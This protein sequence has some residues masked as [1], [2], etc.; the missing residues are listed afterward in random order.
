MTEQIYDR[1]KAIV[2][3]DRVS[4]DHETLQQY[5][6]DQSFVRPCPP[7]YV[8][9]AESVQEI[10]DVVK[11]ANESKTPVVPVSSRMNLRGA[12]IPKEGGI[13]LD[14]SRMNKIGEISE[15]ERWAVVEPGVTYGQLSE[16]LQKHGFRVMIPLG[17][18]RSRSVVSSIIERDPALAAA[19][20][21]YGN[22]I[23][24]EIAMVLPSGEIFRTG[25]WRM[26]LRGEWSSPGGGGIGSAQTCYEWLWHKAQGTLGIITG[27]VV[28][29]EHF[30]K[31]SKVFVFPFDRLE[32]AIEPIRKIQRKELGL[33]CFLLNNF[34]LAAIRTQDWDVPEGFPCERVPST[35]FNSL[36]GRLP[37]WTMIIHLAGLPYFPEEK[38]A[39]EEAD[40][41]DVCSEMGLSPAQT[42]VGEEGLE[43]T[44]LDLTL[45][46]WMSLKKARFKGSFHPVSFYTTLGRVP[47]FEEA[48]SALAQKYGYS[49]NDI[50][51]YL[52]PVERG[53]NCYYEIDFHCDL[54]DS[55]EVRR[56]KNLWLEANEVCAG[57]GAVLAKP[58]G[59]CADIIYRGFNPAYVQTLKSWK[60]ELDPSN[61]LNPG[62][63]CF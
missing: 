10:Q 48:V 49:L 35:E 39:Y 30:P 26:L 53:R 43:G 63:L 18:P 58:Y 28:K 50:G 17:V 51:E 60:K 33:E 31:A 40:L 59:P 55:G 25:K 13:I 54:D 41:R 23:H 5:S 1:L 21:E 62:Q 37:K 47:E 4:I 45:H 12:A 36:R 61:I 9:F 7:E 15:R 22:S 19:S 38:V 44:L 56:V 57:M 27:M 24:M 2:G 16:E 32:E 6:K 14:L 3:A 29:A 34:N 20:F 42:V 8:V 11:A 52:L 46:P